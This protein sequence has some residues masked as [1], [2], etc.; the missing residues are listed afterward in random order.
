MSGSWVIS[1]LADAPYGVR[2]E[3][4]WLYDE[5]GHGG[6]P[7]WFSLRLSH[8]RAVELRDAF[9]DEKDEGGFS[10]LIKAGGRM[11]RA[12][13]A[14]LSLALEAIPE[15]EPIGADILVPPQAFT[16]LLKLAG[17][18]PD[19]DEYADLDIAD[20]GLAIEDDQEVDLSKAPKKFT[21]RNAKSAFNKKGTP[22]ASV[23]ETS[24]G[25]AQGDRP[26]GPVI[27]A[28][29]DDAVGI[30]N[31][32][33][34]KAEKETRVAHFLD[35]GPP[36]AGPCDP[37]PE[38]ELLARSWTGEQINTLLD[39]YPDDDERVYRALGLIGRRDG[40]QPLR[41]AASH[42]THMLDTAAGYDS[43]TTDEA[44]RAALDSRT[45]IAVQLPPQCP[46]DRSDSWLPQSLKRALDWI[47]V[48]ADELS[49]ELTGGI[50]EPPRLPLIVNCSFG[51]MAG[52]RDGQSDLERRITQFVETYRGA[53]G[54]EKLCTVVLSAGNFLPTRTAAC[55]SPPGTPEGKPLCWRI[56]PDDKTP[57][58]VE[59]WGPETDVPEQQLSVTLKPPGDAPTSPRSCLDK[60]VDWK[61]GKV[62]Y[63]RLYH[64]ILPRPEGKW[65]ECVTIAARPT[66]DDGNNEPVAPF[67]A[68]EIEV[69]AGKLP[70][71]KNMTQYIYLRVH[72]DDPGMYAHGKG[73]QSYF[74]DPLYER[75]D[76]RT[77]A[78][79][80]DERRDAGR[81]RSG[82]PV[83]LV[84]MQG[85]LSAYGYAK[86]VLVVGGYRRSD[87]N[88]VA[89][90]S[91]GAAGIR[92][93]GS[94]LEGPDI[95]AVTEESP[96]L[97]GI[98]GTGTYSGSVEFLNGTSVAAPLAVRALADEI[99][100]GGSLETLK[101]E[102]ARFE[103]SRPGLLQIYEPAEKRPLR[104][105][106]GRL[107]FR[108]SYR[109][110][111]EE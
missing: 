1:D 90:S 105:G 57:S 51:S 56:Q 32:R 65:R 34:R 100:G 27:I 26:H 75:F 80:S 88:P 44:E 28:I 94:S 59:I 102:V 18:N 23:G 54:P 109:I 69:D 106:D 61:I 77:G 35:L 7:L 92:R 39:R 81:R 37:E 5:I 12:S 8:A 50:G 48:K 46:E 64:Q 98:L 29:I 38:D 66:A 72:R 70:K 2:P 99:A 55:I 67:G 87:G 10:A 86:G 62:V 24:R 71:P 93:R 17:R 31:R 107:P 9:T 40:R 15:T 21:L 16:E 97:W 104:L 85:T 91:S 89:Y 82:K 43:E 14:A 53:D 110:R 83:S 101:K 79:A 19:K 33:F 68:W 60:L 73:R 36:C 6:K 45:I 4:H 20:A 84:T 22:P 30:A 47:L 95:A 74:D 78:T 63:A 52:P 3:T 42:G 49:A 13:H 25:M 76:P 111:V 96:A 41:A 103:A 58:F 11:A 108:S